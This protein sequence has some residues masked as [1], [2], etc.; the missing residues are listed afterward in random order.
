[1]HFSQFER[2]TLAAKANQGSM[3]R[4]MWCFANRIKMVADLTKAVE[5][6][7][8]FMSVVSHELR[9]PLNGV[10]GKAPNPHHA[11]LPCDQEPSTLCHHDVVAMGILVLM[12]YHG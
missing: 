12:G 11:A 8:E 1:M 9:T 7:E 10:I 2:C 5:A 4:L 3:L 6:K